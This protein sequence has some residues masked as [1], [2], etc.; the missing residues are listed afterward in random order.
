MCFTALICQPGTSKK[1]DYHVN[2]MNDLTTDSKKIH[3]NF[4]IIE[5][6]RHPRG[7]FQVSMQ[8]KLT[9]QA[10]G[11]ALVNSQRAWSCGVKRERLKVLIRHETG[12]LGRETKAR[13]E[14]HCTRKKDK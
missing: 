11:N 13:Q 2:D 4:P 8:G 10:K 9:T 14:V 5:H 7:L 1:G 12:A 6:H 3:S